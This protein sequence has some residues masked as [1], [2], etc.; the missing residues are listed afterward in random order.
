MNDVLPPLKEE[1]SDDLTV[2]E[3]A[4][5]VQTT[6]LEELVEALKEMR[7]PHCGLSVRVTEHHLRR[8]QKRFFWRVQLACDTA[9]SSSKLFEADWW[10]TR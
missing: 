5:A 3:V 6:K 4:T 9:H 8:Y 7:C 1:D 2:E 10:R